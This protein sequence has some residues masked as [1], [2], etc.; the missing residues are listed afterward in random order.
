MQILKLILTNSLICLAISKWSS[1]QVEESQIIVTI[2]EAPNT[3]IYN[4]GDEFVVDLMYN[5]SLL[6]S[7]GDERL[8]LADSSLQ[9]DF[10]FLGSTYDEKSDPATDYPML[11]FSNSKLVGIDYFYSQAI[12]DDGNNSFFRFFKDQSFNYSPDGVSEYS[13]EYNVVNIPEP[14]QILVFGISSIFLLSIRKRKK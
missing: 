9:L 12:G 8:S 7:D 14:S 4:A 1:A 6:K 13:G 11:Y 2:S 5:K 10:N 3:S